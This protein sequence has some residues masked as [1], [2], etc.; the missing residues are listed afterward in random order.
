M[1]NNTVYYNQNCYEHDEDIKL[2]D[3]PEIALYAKKGNLDKIKELLN[4]GVNPNSKDKYSDTA[5]IWTSNR[6]NLDIV[7][8]LLKY[9][10]D[11]NIKNNNSRTALVVASLYNYLDIVKELLKYNANVD[12]KNNNDRVAFY[13][14]KGKVKVKEYFISQGVVK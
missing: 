3:N 9:N 10:A 12:I 6:G 7:K 14:A 4:N 13:Y 11:V 2:I 8:E 1:K 5:L